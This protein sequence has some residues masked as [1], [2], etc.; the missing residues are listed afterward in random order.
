MQTLCAAPAESR[1]SDMAKIRFFYSYE[2]EVRPGIWI[3]QA[4]TVS[5]D[6]EMP[7]RHTWTDTRL[8][9]KR[10]K[11]LCWIIDESLVDYDDRHIYMCGWF[12]DAVTSQWDYSECLARSVCRLSELGLVDLSMKVLHRLHELYP[13][14]LISQFRL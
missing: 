6:H 12:N 2:I 11:K 13:D 4:G 14:R 1:V 5:F 8:Y 9:N 7:S 3:E 10:I